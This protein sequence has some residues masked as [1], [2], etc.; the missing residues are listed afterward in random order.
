MCKNFKAFYVPSLE[1]IEFLANICEMPITDF[2][3]TNE[4]IDPYRNQCVRGTR[5]F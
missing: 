3:S 4:T 2:G 5:Q 1:V